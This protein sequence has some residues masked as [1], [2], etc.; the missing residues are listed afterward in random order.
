MT[1]KL[2]K[3]D[4]IYKIIDAGTFSNERKRFISKIDKNGKITILTY[5]FST[6]DIKEDGTVQKEN[7]RMML[8]I[9]EIEEKQFSFVI[10]TNYRIYP[11][12][13]ILWEKDYSDKSLEEAIELMNIDGHIKTDAALK[14]IITEIRE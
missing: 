2:N 9:R 4:R 3:G 12:F 1:L 13:K 10:D 5:I 14:D 8:L 6:D 11:Q 7:K